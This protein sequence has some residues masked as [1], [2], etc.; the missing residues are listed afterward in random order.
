VA[1]QVESLEAARVSAQHIENL[2]LRFQTMS[3]KLKEQHVDMW[4][5]LESAIKRELLI[6]GIDPSS[7]SIP[8]FEEEEEEEEEAEMAE[9]ESP[10]PPPRMVE[11]EEIKTPRVITPKKIQEPP[12]EDVSGWLWKKAGGK[13]DAFG[14]SGLPLSPRRS[15]WNKRWFEL[16]GPVLSYYE[17]AVGV[18]STERKGK[19]RPIWSGSLLTAETDA[20]GRLLARALVGANRRSMLE[21]SFAS[22]K[23]LLGTPS[24]ETNEDRLRGQAVLEMWKA[25]LHKHHD[26]YAVAMEED[27]DG[28]EDYSEDGF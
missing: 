1:C 6:H 26:Y 27:G 21:V 2:E 22:R 8:I 18:D 16:K 3:S 25:R 20:S 10:S 28:S 23:I 4:Q 15:N 13:T 17:E 19:G 14:N 7:F 24:A 9:E 5:W 12:P 11:P